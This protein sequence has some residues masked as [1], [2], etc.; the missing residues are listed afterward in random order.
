MRHDIDLVKCEWSVRYPGLWAHMR[1]SVDPAK[2][3]CSD[4]YP[5]LPLA[6]MFLIVQKKN[7]TFIM[8]ILQQFLELKR[9]LFFPKC[10][11]CR[12]YF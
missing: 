4:G 5:L 1:H 11:I 7:K 2:C 6:R 8:I 10:F 12:T 9:K 3:E